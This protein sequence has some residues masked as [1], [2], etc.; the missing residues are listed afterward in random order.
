MPRV[1]PLLDAYNAGEVS[2]R[3]NARTSLEKYR[4]AGET[5]VNMYAAVEGALLRR[6]GSRYAWTVKDSNKVARLMGREVGVGTAYVLELGDLS[7]RFGRNQQRI[8]VLVT[9]TVIANGTFAAGIASWTNRSTGTPGG[10]IAHD[11]PGQRLQL[12]PNGT[13]ADDIGWAEQAVAVAGGD[14]GKPHVLRFRVD[15]AA[16]NHVYCRI[17]TSS[18]GSELLADRKCSVGEHAIR[19][20]PNAGTIYVQFLNKGSDNDASGTKF[21]KALT[22]DNVSFLSGQALELTTP[23]PEVKLFEVVASQSDDVAFLL[24]S[25]YAPRSLQRWSGEDES[26]SLVALDFEDGPWLDEND[27]DTTLTPGAT[28]GAAVTFTAS[29][30]KGIND[31]RGFLSTDVG[32][33]IRF[34]P[35][36]TNWGYGVI[37]S[38]T[39]AMHVKVDIKRGLAGTPASTKWRLGAWSDTT[40][41]PGCGTFLGQRFWAARSTAQPKTFWG[42]ETGTFTAVSLGYAPDSPNA[43]GI[44]DG[45]VED[46]DAITYTVSSDGS[47]S[48]QAL[49]A[50]PGKTLAIFTAGGEY[51][52]AT[53]GGTITPTDIDVQR[54][55]KYG[56][57]PVQPLVVGPYAMFL[58]RQKRKIRVFGFDFERDGYVAQNAMR[59]ARHIAKGGIAEMA[60]QEEPA[61]IV[62]AV[63]GDGQLLAFTF[64]PD[65]DVAGWTR[66]ILGGS[67]LDGAAVVESVTVIPGA[68]GAGQVASSEDRDE[69]WLIVKRT[70]NGTIARHVEFLEGDFEGPPRNTYDSHDDWAAAMIA[71]QKDVY[72]ADALATYD[73]APTST[74]AAPHLAGEMVKVWAD[75]AIHP[76]VMLDAAGNGTLDAA[77]ST[78]QFGLAYRHVLQSL[79]LDYGAAS[80]TAVGKTR[81][82]SGV[83]LVVEYGHAYQFGPDLETL[84][85]ADFREVTDAMDSAVPLYAGEKFKEFEGDW[86]NDPRFVIASDA[87]APFVLLAAVPELKTNEW[88]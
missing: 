75:G 86:S 69:V 31:G 76:D 52:I 36:A 82:I 5:V 54:H 85:A 39:D 3:L 42:T 15:G 51:V 12:S 8:D 16:G 23:Y 34:S 71:A 19:V 11:A 53:S 26:W 29:A 79:K 41:W 47:D 43:S 72:Y 70:I 50:A 33:L 56:S 6:P 59:L 64:G 57:S 77:Y 14:Q 68:N 60:Y 44:W 35:A 7:L 38:V 10:A 84:T 20:T 37:V 25:D 1:S 74:I 87:P 24:H 40:G 61:S 81:Q 83:T 45:T 2:P 55:T 30:T 73:G 21:D 28:T 27:T 49:S 80:G 62:W 17:G 48:I 66:M 9:S 63:R 32:R 88:A 13:D 67:Y 22:I 4:N 58:Q 78:I 46:D 65:E 18:T